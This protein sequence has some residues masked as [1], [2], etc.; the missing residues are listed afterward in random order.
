MA[1]VLSWEKRLQV[2]AA[3]VDG[4]SARAMSRMTGVHQD[5]IGRFGLMLGERAQWLHNRLARD[6]RPS[7]LEYDEQWG[8]VGVKGPRLRPDHP[9]GWGEQWSWV[10]LDTASRFAVSFVVGPR[11]GDTA[12]RFIA[13]IRSRVSTMPKVMTSDGLALYEEPILHAFGAPEYAQVV[14]DFKGRPQRSPDHRYEPPRDPMVTKRAVYGAPDLDHASTSHLERQNATMRHKNGRMRR[15]CYAFSKRL[16]NHCAAV[17]LTYTAYNF[18]N[19][20]R[21]SR[22][23]PAMAIGVTSG[24]W[25]LDQFLEELLRAE[26]CDPPEAQPLAFVQP[27]T[28]AR[29]L[30]NGRGYLRVVP[31]PKGGPSPVAP[32]A[33]APPPPPAA[34]VAAPAAPPARPALRVAPKKPVQLSLFDLMKKGSDPDQ[35][36]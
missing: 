29:E 21:T 11:N 19:I 27:A 31:D 23:T 26:P 3:M 12:K 22:I 16:E 24:P 34:P 6:L 36:P 4:N 10:A 33:P 18:C 2:L 32:P 7:F 1:N 30:P 15:L 8:W 20:I 14:K 17:A 35:V 9:E 5:T 28:T 25:E 13:D